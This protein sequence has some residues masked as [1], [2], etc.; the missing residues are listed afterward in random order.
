MFFT[1][2][3]SSVFDQGFSCSFVASP[4]E[5]SGTICDEREDVAW[6]EPNAIFCILPRSILGIRPILIVYQNFFT[7]LDVPD[8]LQAPNLAES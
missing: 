1:V 3:S 8:S 4:F 5:V 6:G 7:L 2:A